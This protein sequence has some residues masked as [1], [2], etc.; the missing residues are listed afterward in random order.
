M[1]NQNGYCMNKPV[2]VFFIFSCLISWTIWLFMILSN[3]GII[4]IE[5]PRVIHFT[6]PIG[7]L[8]GAIIASRFTDSI[9]VKSLFQRLFRFKVPLK[10]YLISIFIPVLA[11][12]FSAF[13]VF[14]I[15]QDPEYRFNSIINAFFIFLTI[16]FIV[17]GEEI[18]WRGFALPV[19]QAKFSP[20][21]SS[22]IVG[23]MW[24]VWHIPAFIVADI[25]ESYA[26]L[27]LALL[28]F[29]I[30]C[31]VL[32]ILFTWVVNSSGGSTFMAVLMHSSIAA[33]SSITN[34]ALRNPVIFFTLFTLAFLILAVGVVKKSTVN[35]GVKDS[36]NAK[37]QI[38]ET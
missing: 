25:F 13:L 36:S 4:G 14:L 11:Y 30:L 37:H 22:F 1:Q 6:T 2:Y 16:P 24:A 12:G 10:W 38:Q 34:I 7:P 35:L 5:I 20:L 9:T 33:S 18:G 21:K 31:M 26:H 17:F 29:V 19:L 8:I 32:S 28:G 3:N 15:V 27:L 23:L